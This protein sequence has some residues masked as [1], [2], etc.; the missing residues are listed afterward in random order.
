MHVCLAN[1]VKALFRTL[2]TGWGL[3]QNMT[4]EKGGGDLIVFTVTTRTILHT[5]SS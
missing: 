1:I 3:L 5:I 4:S 2:V